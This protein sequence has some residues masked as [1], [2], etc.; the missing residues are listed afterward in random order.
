MISFLLKS[1]DISILSK[2]SFISLYF[3]SV[4]A[5]S[6]H[7]NSL[8]CSM[9]LILKTEISVGNGVAMRSH[10]LQKGRAKSRKTPTNGHYFFYRI[11]ICICC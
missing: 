2:S 4:S 10:H 7:A 9:L 3:Y 5:T 8:S 6:S 1:F 11:L